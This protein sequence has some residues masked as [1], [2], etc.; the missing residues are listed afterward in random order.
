LKSKVGNLDIKI[1][2]WQG[3]WADAALEIQATKQLP[4][5]GSLRPAAVSQAGRQPLG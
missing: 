5:T 3:T 4:A 2:S 1:P